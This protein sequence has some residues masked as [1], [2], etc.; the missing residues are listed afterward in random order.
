MKLTELMVDFALLGAEWV[1]WLLVV[2]SIL[3]VA[4]MIER[5]LF[6]R[7][8]MLDLDRFAGAVRRAITDDSLER[9]EKEYGA[10][11]SMATRVALAGLR[12][13]KRGPEAASEEM[14]SAKARERQQHDQNL[15]FLG[16]LGNNAPF[17]GLFGT[18]LGVILALHALADEPGGN[19]DVVM[20][21]I[22]EALVATAVGLFVAVPA[23]MSFNFFNRRVRA[24]LAA[25]DTIAHVI[26][27]EIHAGGRGA[28]APL[29]ERGG[30][31]EKEDED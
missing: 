25:T 12:E 21:G 13:R 28:E 7:K 23:V 22:Y 2:L 4:V 9:V 26:L 15:V 3:S 30:G 29:P 8:R 27:G 10:H 18:V 16:T 24:A 11:P 19:I 5:G 6:F 14:N 20:E 31:G 1:L 17:I